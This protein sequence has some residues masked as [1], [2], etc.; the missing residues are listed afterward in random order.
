MVMKEK[1]SALMDGE[2]DAKA[3]D[4]LLRSLP[5]DVALRRTWERWHLIRASLHQDLDV[6]A[7]AGLVA[8]VAGS[9]RDEPTVLAPRR[10]FLP[11]RRE[12]TRWV[13][14]AAIAASV[15]AV[16]V[17]GMRTL[18]GVPEAVPA[19]LLAQNSQPARRG[20]LLRASDTQW[21]TPSPEVRNDLNEFLVEHSEFNPAARMN[22]MMSYVRIVGY[23]SEQ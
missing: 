11:D 13:G 8:A 5:G 12:W 6:L 1:I 9:L 16:S 4:D 18:N 3:A 23:D 20:G 15:A 14:G 19:A 21:E 17:V 7:P 2:L 22:G 10:R